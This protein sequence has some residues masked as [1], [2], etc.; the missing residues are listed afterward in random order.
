LDHLSKLLLQPFQSSLG[1]SQSG[2]HASGMLHFGIRASD[3][4]HAGGVRTASY[5]RYFRYDFS[6]NAHCANHNI[7]GNATVFRLDYIRV[8]ACRTDFRSRFQP[9]RRVLLEFA[10][11]P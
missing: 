5:A 2:T 7:A 8:I 6:I 11:C 4:L 1:D 3:I 10:H 9:P